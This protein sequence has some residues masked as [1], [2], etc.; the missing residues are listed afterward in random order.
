MSLVNLVPF[1]VKINLSRASKET[2]TLV[3]GT[4]MDFFFQISHDEHF[5]F[6]T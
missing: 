6:H 3:S 2:L 1:G 5:Q 4:L